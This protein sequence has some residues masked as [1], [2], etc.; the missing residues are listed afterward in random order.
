MNCPFLASGEL[1]VGT[2]LTSPHLTS[3]THTYTHVPFSSQDDIEI[4]T[5]T[6]TP[7]PGSHLP[8]HDRQ[9]PLHSHLHTSQKTGGKKW[10]KETVW[11][12]VTEMHRWKS[13]H[14]N[15]FHDSV[16][17]G[18]LLAAGAPFASSAV[19]TKPLLSQRSK[20]Y[21]YHGGDSQFFTTHIIHTD[22][23]LANAYAVTN[24]SNIFA[25]SEERFWNCSARWSSKTAWR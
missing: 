22:Q 17:L 9:L 7:P 24:V 2:L 25:F 8:S 16:S 13:W 4:P 14:L 21:V 20:I 10:R 23:A 1:E 3:S 5:L 15:D 12:Y 18:L 11:F 6:H 19:R